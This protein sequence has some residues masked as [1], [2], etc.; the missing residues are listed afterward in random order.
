MGD[1][2]KGDYQ[3]PTAQSQTKRMLTSLIKYG[4][5]AARTVQDI[6]EEIQPRQQALQAGL[7]Q[8]YAPIL[9]QLGI[10]LSGQQQLGDVANARETIAGGGRELVGDTMGLDRIINPEF[11]ANRELGASG[12]Q[13]LI[14]GM[15][16]NKLSGAELAGV[17]R[18]VNRLNQHRGNSNIEDS[19]TTA[20]NALQFDDRL[21]QKR[22]AFG[23]ALNLI[24]GIQS[25]SRSPIDAFNVA[26]GR[27]SS[28]PNFGQQQFQNVQPTETGMN[29][30]QG[31][32]GTQQQ[33]QAINAGRRTA[34]DF[35]NQALTAVGSA[36]GGVS[37]AACCFI[38]LEAYNGAL[39]SS[40]RLCRDFFYRQQPRTAL[41]YKRMA[42]WI[43]PLMKRWSLIRNI[44]D[45]FMVKPMT[46]YGEWLTGYSPH[47]SGK[48]ITK[49]WLNIWRIYAIK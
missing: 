3:A 7:L 22:Q 6:E 18:G 4:P 36:A 5:K 11:Y 21:Q 35:T 29:F 43:V 15:D 2:V 37:G 19:T 45:I 24:P 42:K 48:L 30:L 27:S 32:Q 34:Q 47:C 26:T 8:Q 10:D 40:V 44:I 1:L 33:Q 38:F 12:L 20:A 17:E 13:T 49:F 31:I 28:T 14:G 23:Q 16:P 25:A 9:T 41:G 39:P 46:K